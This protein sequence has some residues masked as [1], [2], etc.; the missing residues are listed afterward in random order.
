GPRA[1]ARR[2]RRVRASELAEQAHAEPGRRGTPP[3]ARELREQQWRQQPRTAELRRLVAEGVGLAPA[4]NERIAP[5][6]SG[7]GFT[8]AS[9]RLWTR[10]IEARI[11]AKIE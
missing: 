2:P 3:R 4:A 9:R 1:Q 5:W 10:G 8:P 7:N 11:M 6:T